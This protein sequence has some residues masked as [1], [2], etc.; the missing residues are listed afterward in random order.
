MASVFLK[1][2]TKL[3]GWLDPKLE[4]FRQPKQKKPPYTPKSSKALIELLQ[5]TPESILNSRQRTAI[6]SAM[7]YQDIPVSSIMAKTAH[8]VTLHE[9]DVLG[10]LTLDRLYKTGLNTFPVLDQNDRI[11]G[12]LRTDSIDTL[13]VVENETKLADCIDRNICFVRADYSLD[14]LLA[15]FI[16]TNN[17]FC[18]V[19]NHDGDVCGYVSLAMFIMKFFGEEVLDNFELDADKNAVLARRE[20]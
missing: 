1:I 12:I 15:A 9:D 5:R 11:C 14:M 8:V 18:I 19:L 13:R 20:K 4:K 7:S 3:V 16:R 2:M 6:A 10:A 17:N